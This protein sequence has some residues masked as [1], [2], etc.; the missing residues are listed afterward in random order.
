MIPINPFDW[1]DWY[2]QSKSKGALEL[3]KKEAKAK[4]ETCLYE[5]PRFTGA[6]L[7]N[8]VWYE[9][10]VEA[11][12]LTAS[13]QVKNSLEDKNVEESICKEL[14][15]SPER[16]LNIKISVDFDDKIGLYWVNLKDIG[17]IKRGLYDLKFRPS[18][19]LGQGHLN[20]KTKV[21]ATSDA[22]FNKEY[23]SRRT[24]DILSAL[25]K[26]GMEIC[27]IIGQAIPNEELEMGKFN[28]YNV[29][30]ASVESSDPQI[31][32]II[33][34]Y[35]D[36]ETGKIYTDEDKKTEI[37]DPILTRKIIDSY[38]VLLF[39]ASQEQNPPPINRTIIYQ[40]RDLKTGEKTSFTTT[41]ERLRK[42]IGI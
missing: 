40:G 38:G 7:A 21:V 32:D 36:T 31:K 1:Y 2:K 35:L 18:V 26:Q 34:S 33:N 20:M 8:I 22:K 39:A 29:C 3:R 24:I 5:P 9:R 12:I 16:N 37:T 6:S 27:Q 13:R 11:D 30:V 10:G 14:G 23:T 25:S 17:L 28:H 15:L 42:H 19:V 4:K 41:E